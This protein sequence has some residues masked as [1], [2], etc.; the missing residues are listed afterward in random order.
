MTKK[1]TARIVLCT[2]IFFTQSYSMDHDNN[3][4]DD[5]GLIAALQPILHKARVYDHQARGLFRLVQVADRKEAHIMALISDGKYPEVSGALLNASWFVSMF[6]KNWMRQEHMN[7]EYIKQRF[8]Q[9]RAVVER[10]K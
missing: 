4:G 10:H 3:A 8:N 6:T 5:L 7:T 9:Y 1:Y 2:M